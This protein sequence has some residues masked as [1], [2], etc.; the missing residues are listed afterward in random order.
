MLG[1]LG[2][3]I[4]LEGLPKTFWGSVFGVP[5]TPPKVQPLRAEDTS[6]NKVLGFKVLDLGGGFIFLIFTHIWGRLPFWVIF[7][8]GVETTNQ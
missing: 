5:F 8:R 3:G 4:L 6:K 2:E 1:E 7:F